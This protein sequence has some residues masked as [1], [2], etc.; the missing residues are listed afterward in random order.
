MMYPAA[1]WAVPGSRASTAT[2]PG[3]R[4]GRG[5]RRHGC[6]GP[7]A[8]R[9]RSWLQHRFGHGA[10]QADARFEEAVT[11]GF[12][13]LETDEIAAAEHR[14][15]ERL[16]VVV[17]PYGRDRRAPRAV[18]GEPEGHRTTRHVGRDLDEADLGFPAGETADVNT[19][20]TVAPLVGP[21]D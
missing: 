12:R 1:T 4:A 9:S 14:H 18:V 19:R 15:A 3:P 2:C 10:G 20:L 5:R 8:T 7:N 6:A 17:Q 21:G 13:K 16:D 11:S